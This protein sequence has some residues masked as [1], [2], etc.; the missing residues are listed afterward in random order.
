MGANGGASWRGASAGA[1]KEKHDR[2]P[3]VGRGR[4]RGPDPN[5]SRDRPPAMVPPGQPARRVRPGPAG[6]R[7]SA[8]QRLRPARGTARR[9]TAAGQAGTASGVRP[10]AGIRLWA[11]GLRPAR[12]RLRRTSRPVATGPAAPKP[13]VIP[14]RPMAVGE[15]LDGAFTSIRRNPKAILGM[16]AVVMTISAIIRDHQPGTASTCPA[17]VNTGADQTLPARSWP[18]SRGGDTQRRDRP[19]AGVHRPDP[20][21]RAARPPMIARGVAGPADQRRRR[22]AGR[23]APAARPAG[24]DA[25]QGA[26]RHRP[27]GRAGRRAI[28]PGWPARRERWS[29][30]CSSLGPWPL[31]LTIW[32]STMLSL[33]G[34]PR[35]AGAP[36]TPARRWPGPGGW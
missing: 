2:H 4:S 34:G 26:G 6:S 10:G 27:L 29:T 3:A 23:A 35:G 18:D 8:R 13:G 22:V 21:D 16:A 19:A 9:G 17:G 30:R 33:V 24:R 5:R 1:A 25:A 14:L 31:V 15:I 7:R 20:A 32:F 36:G 11:A 12:N 28:V